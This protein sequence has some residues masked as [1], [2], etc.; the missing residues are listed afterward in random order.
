MNKWIESYILKIIFLFKLF[1][2]SK[3]IFIRMLLRNYSS[4]ISGWMIHLFFFH[5]LSY[6][7]ILL[8]F[9]LIFIFCIIRMCF[10]RVILWTYSSNNENHWAMRFS[11]H[12]FPEYLCLITFRLNEFDLPFA[13]VCILNIIWFLRQE[14]LLTNC[15]PFLI[16]SVLIYLLIKS[17]SKMVK[18]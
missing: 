4:F 17:W 9:M 18:W 5:F 8:A 10:F 11:F 1:I 16:C 6:H 2:I 14:Y 15:Y 3:K 13:Y 12:S 7:I